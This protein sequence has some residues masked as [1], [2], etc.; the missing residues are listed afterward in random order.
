MD[1]NLTITALRA[2]RLLL[3]IIEY[4]IIIR[5]IIS[6][7][8]VPKD[9]ALVRLLYQITEPILSPIRGMIEKSSFGRNSMIDISPIV[10][11]LVVTI[12]RRML[13]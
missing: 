13:P 9:N 2:L 8:P 5:A 4:S 10:A 7:F 11:L 12:V 1:G 3:V 6:W